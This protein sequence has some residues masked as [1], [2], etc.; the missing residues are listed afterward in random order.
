MFTIQCCNLAHESI[1][2]CGVTR[3]TLEKHWNKS[4]AVKP[5]W[6]LP[7]KH[8][9]WHISADLDIC[10]ANSFLLSHLKRHDKQWQTL[11]TIDS[12]S[13]G[14]TSNEMPG[15]SNELHIQLPENHWFWDSC[16]INFG[17]DNKPKVS[18]DNSQIELAVISFL[19]SIFPYMS[20]IHEN[21]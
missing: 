8:G 14:C 4:W 20:N 15:Y 12:E 11:E 1:Q 5:R 19:R 21:G 3:H 18:T 2:L 17:A 13:R 9:T 16:W 7:L 10:L 6:K